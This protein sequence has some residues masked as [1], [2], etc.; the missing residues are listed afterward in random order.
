MHFVICLSFILM[1]Y[2]TDNGVPFDA[3]SVEANFPDWLSTMT[4][5]QAPQSIQKMMQ[6]NPNGLNPDVTY[7]ADSL[8]DGKVPSSGLVLKSDISS[9]DFYAT[10]GC[11]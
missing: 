2:A 10:G 5:D 6:Q 1:C 3:I 7:T 9:I 8:V 4:L 11:Q